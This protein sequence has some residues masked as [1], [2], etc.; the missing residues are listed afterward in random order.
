MRCNDADHQGELNVTRSAVRGFSGAR[1]RRI[2]TDRG[3]TGDELADAAG[4]SYQAISH[5]ETGRATPTPPRLARI[6]TALNVT[7][8]DL[9]VIPL[10]KRNLSDLRVQAGLTQAQ[11]GESAEL[12]QPV[13]ANLEKG[14]VE[15]DAGRAAR[16]AAALGVH[17]PE[18]EAA[19]KNSR[20]TRAARIRQISS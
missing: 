10:A 16:L 9:V 8:S 2:R 17:T 12:S 6:A 19:W 4:V 11:L 1:L 14:R 5:W 7:I 18:V 3:L 13:V 15:F 20:A